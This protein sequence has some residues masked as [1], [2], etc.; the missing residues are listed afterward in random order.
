MIT[1]IKVGDRLYVV[2]QYG[3]FLRTIGWVGKD[4][5]EWKWGWTN[6]DKINHNTKQGSRVKF[7]YTELDLDDLRS[8]YESTYLAYVKGNDYLEFE[9]WL[10]EYKK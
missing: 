1:D 10:K 3:K 5:V 4:K 6:I 2:N 8:E 7:I 9:Q